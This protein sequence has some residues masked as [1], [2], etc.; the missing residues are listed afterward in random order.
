MGEAIG[1]LRRP[2]FGCQ[3]PPRV[4]FP[5]RVPYPMREPRAV[6][7][8]HRA[9]SLYRGTRK[10]GNE[11]DEPCFEPAGTSQLSQRGFQHDAL[12]GFHAQGVGATG[13]ERVAID[14]GRGRGHAPCR[15]PGASGPR[16]RE[17]SR[18]GAGVG[19]RRASGGARAGRESRCEGVGHAVA[20]LRRMEGV[21]A[22]LHAD[23]DDDGVLRV[24]QLS[25]ARLLAMGRL[26]KGSR[27]A[28]RRTRG[29]DVARRG[30]RDRRSRPAAVLVLRHRRLPQAHDVVAP[31]A[32]N[33]LGDRSDLRNR[34]GIQFLV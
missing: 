5:L 21:L 30:A 14:H 28:L 1:G 32:D 24:L 20:G 25:V 9:P 19:R 29:A 34:G 6:R 16:D 8:Q 13:H 12:L 11:D 7:K 3:V 2:E 22:E 26:D 15:W 27:P 4:E 31:D 17:V 18:G 23:C 33:P 10:D